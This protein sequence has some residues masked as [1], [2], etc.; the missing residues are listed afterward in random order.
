MRPTNIRY[1]KITK[2]NKKQ[3][4]PFLAEKTKNGISYINHP[5]KESVIIDCVTL[6]DYIKFHDIEYTILDGVYW[7]EGGNKNIGATVK[8]L[9]LERLKAKKEKK[10]ALQQVL[11]LM[12]NSIY[13]KTITKKVHEESLIIPIKVKVYDKVTKSWK[14][15]ERTDFNNYVH[16]NFNTLK[17]YRKINDHTYEIDRSKA[18]FSYSRGHIGCMILSYSKRIM[19]ELMDLADKNKMPVYYSDTDSLH[20]NWDDYEALENH[21]K[22]D[23]KKVLTGKN[24][25][26][27]HPDFS[28]KGANTD[29]FSVKSIF[30]GKKSY[31]DSLQSTDINGKIIRG[32]HIRLKGITLEGINDAKL[33][34]E[35][36]AF[37][38]FEHLASGKP[39]NFLL[40]PY[41]V[42][43]NKTKVLFEYPES[44]GV[45]FKT[46]FY[47]KLQF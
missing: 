36:D 14:L 34:F 45:R 27:F 47:R 9:F 11:K 31:I 10:D 25:E 21:Y 23:Y 20:M 30:L 3:Q 44:G 6:E 22:K 32:Y 19:N 5:P 4:M 17:K 24:L 2:V 12:L 43:E 33:Q 16:N 28:L 38:M 40:N 29:I 46:P 37:K 42:E 18:D 13:G 1:T 15:N 39:V 7:D 41:N 26:Q 8:S 35:D